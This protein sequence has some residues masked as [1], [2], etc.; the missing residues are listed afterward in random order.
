MNWTKEL[1]TQL[2]YDYIED[3]SYGPMLC[4]AFDEFWPNGWEWGEFNGRP[5]FAFP[6]QE[7]KWPYLMQLTP[8]YG[9]CGWCLEGAR[10]GDFP[11]KTL[12]EAKQQAEAALRLRLQLGKPTTWKEGDEA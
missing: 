6:E 4:D 12:Q 5:A 11:T 9:Q 3:P 2:A 7:K 1:L 8:P 10:V